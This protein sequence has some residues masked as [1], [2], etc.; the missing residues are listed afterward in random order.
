M[1]TKLKRILSAAAALVL[2]GGIT[3]AVALRDAGQQEGSNC[4]EWAQMVEKVSDA[5][6]ARQFYLAVQDGATIPKAAGSYLLGDC[7]TGTCTYLPQGCTGGYSISL[8]TDDVQMPQTPQQAQCAQAPPPNTWMC[9]ASIEAHEWVT[10]QVV[11]W[12]K[13]DTWGALYEYTYKAGPARN[14]WK[15]YVVEAHPY[16]AKGWQQAAAESAGTIRWYGTKAEVVGACLAHFSGGDCL[17]MLGGAGNGCW[18]LDTGDI[19]RG[20]WLVRTH[21]PGD[22][23]PIA[24]P[25]AQII[26][27]FLCTTSRG[28]GSEWADVQATTEEEMAE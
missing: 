14:G 24:C 16:I 12:K 4:A 2:A 23:P 25:A 17:A 3:V 8:L 1:M 13:T 28:S 19:C 22:N 9:T 10:W 6:A 5:Q 15:V 26:A 20:G 7:A 27:P 21:T 18:L 11:G